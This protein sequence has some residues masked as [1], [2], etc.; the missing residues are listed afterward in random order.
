VGRPLDETNFDNCR[1]AKATYALQSLKRACELIHFTTLHGADRR[2][3]AIENLD[4]ADQR[5]VP[6]KNS[7][8]NGCFLQVFHRSSE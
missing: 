4:D 6:G 5:F 1:R 3:V 7:Q 8:N 2:G